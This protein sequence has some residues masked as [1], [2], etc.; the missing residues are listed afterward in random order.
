MRVHGLSVEDANTFVKEK[1]ER[2]YKKLTPIGKEL[3]QE[4]YDAVMKIL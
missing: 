1:L 4:K 2:S 3:I